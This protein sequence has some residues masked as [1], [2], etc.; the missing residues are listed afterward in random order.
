MESW[1]SLSTQAKVQISGLKA[2]KQPIETVLEVVPPHI[3]GSLYGLIYNH[4]DTRNPGRR[5]IVV[6]T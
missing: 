3:F 4:Y 1:Q 2:E 5:A 6:K